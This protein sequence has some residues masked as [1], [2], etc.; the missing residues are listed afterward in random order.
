MDCPNYWRGV[1]ISK[2]DKEKK[3]LKFC[4]ECGSVHFYYDKKCKCG[5]EFEDIEGRPLDHKE[6]DDFRSYGSYDDNEDD[7]WDDYDDYLILLADNQLEE[8]ERLFI[9]YYNRYDGFSEYPDKGIYYNDDEELNLAIPGVE[10]TFVGYGFIESTENINKPMK[11]EENPYTTKALE[12]IMNIEAGVR[13][14]HQVGY[15]LS[16]DEIIDEFALLGRNVLTDAAQKLFTQIIKNAFELIHPNLPNFIDGFYV[17][18]I[19]NDVLDMITGENE[20]YQSFFSEKDGKLLIK[21]DKKEEFMHNLVKKT[22]REL[23]YDNANI[24]DL[25]ELGYTD[26][27]AKHFF[28]ETRVSFRKF[29]DQ[30]D[31]KTFNLTSFKDKVDLVAEKNPEMPQSVLNQIE[32][33]IIFDSLGLVSQH[34]EVSKKMAEILDIGENVSD[35]INEV[36]Q[37]LKD[38]NED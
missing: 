11:T 21:D 31:G 26:E 10:G 6:F 27:E 5:Y 17:D 23:Y 22:T 4:P 3:S 15:S 33:R 30:G 29:I 16:F 34:P 14:M 28:G 36:V 25:G 37:I 8:E 19:F 13:S 38:S 20:Y 9:H 32:N 2:E 35:K 7:Y 18:T 1:I 24:V 12:R